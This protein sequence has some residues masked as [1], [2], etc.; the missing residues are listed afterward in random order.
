MILLC[1]YL[2]ISSGYSYFSVLQIAP[3]YWKFLA[4][5]PTLHTHADFQ[6]NDLKPDKLFSPVFTTNKITIQFE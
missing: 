3:Q 4:K 2:F 5:I 6:V 1:L